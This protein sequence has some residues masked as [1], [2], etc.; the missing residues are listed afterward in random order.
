MRWL[1]SRL[2]IC[3][4]LLLCRFCRCL[5][6]SWLLLS[7][8]S[9]SLHLLPLNLTQSIQ[10]VHLIFFDADNALNFGVAT[11]ADIVAD[12]EFV[13]KFV[14]A[15]ETQSYFVGEVHGRVEKLLVGQLHGSVN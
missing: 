11:A 14:I 3:L 7:R 12:K 15:V 10:L 5:A 13:D 2:R 6:G 4:L 9:H 8:L 1:S